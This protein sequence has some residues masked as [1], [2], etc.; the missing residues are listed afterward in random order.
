MKLELLQINESLIKPEI[1]LEKHT[2]IINGMAK[3]RPREVPSKIGHRLRD[4]I[5]VIVNRIDEFLRVFLEGFHPFLWVIILFVEGGDQIE[6]LPSGD[7][8]FDQGR[9]P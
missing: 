3:A 4:H 9:Q 1:K 2:I 6:M 7:I 8:I 5:V